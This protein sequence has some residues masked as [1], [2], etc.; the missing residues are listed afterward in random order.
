MSSSLPVQTACYYVQALLEATIAFAV[1][2]TNDLFMISTNVSLNICNSICG[3]TFTPIILKNFSARMFCI[4]RDSIWSGLRWTSHIFILSTSSV[5]PPKYTRRAV[6]NIGR[7]VV[8][9]PQ[10]Y[11]IVSWTLTVRQL[12][13]LI[14]ARLNIG[15]VVVFFLQH[16]CIML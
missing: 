14:Q 8:F 3:K 11:C 4:E 16:Y 15:R 5:P 9:F 10:H 13:Y 6:L 7:I 1:L 12:W 2:A